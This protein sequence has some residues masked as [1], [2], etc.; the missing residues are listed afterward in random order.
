MALGCWGRR[1]LG[2]YVC[3]VS[4]KPLSTWHP[5]AIGPPLSPP[6]RG[7][8]FTKDGLGCCPK[9]PWASGG[10]GED[11]G[12]VLSGAACDA[13]SPTCAIH[14]EGGVA[15]CP[16]SECAAGADCYAGVLLCCFPF[17]GFA[18]CRCSLLVL[19]LCGDYGRFCLLLCLFPSVCFV[20]VPISA[21]AALT[22]D[23]DD[24]AQARRMKERVV[25]VWLAGVLPLAPTPH[26]TAPHQ[27]ER[28]GAWR[29]E[30]CVKWKAGPSGKR[31]H[32]GC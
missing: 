6:K 31:S 20:L 5:C 10:P 18:S 9:P 8:P 27:H 28:S 1:V 23:R 13:F 17:P 32:T 4:L 7:P 22:A 3:R 16:V 29:N 25:M 21:V 19:L 26:R 15:C 30:H 12:G 2:V 24:L 11:T 14:V